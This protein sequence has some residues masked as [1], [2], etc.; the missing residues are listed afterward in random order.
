[1]AEKLFMNNDTYFLTIVR[2]PVERFKSQMQWKEFDTQNIHSEIISLK[3]RCPYLE[4]SGC[5]YLVDILPCS[6]KDDIDTCVEGKHSVFNK[7]RAIN[8]LAKFDLAMVTN[9]MSKSLVIMANMLGFPVE[10]LGTVKLKAITTLRHMYT[11]EEE[12]ILGMYFQG[13]TKFYDLAVEKLEER[14]KELGNNFV[15]QETDN[16][17]KANIYTERLC[18]YQFV[19]GTKTIWEGRSQLTINVTEMLSDPLKMAEC[20]PLL[21]EPTNNLEYYTIEAL[22]DAHK[23]ALKS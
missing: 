10:E 7:T 5:G 23:H 8:H 21:D 1:M 22:E 18:G 13:A 4:S 12:K 19:P 6:R 14:T 15:A 20:L 2:H 17:N 16:L 9:R 3:K 11:E